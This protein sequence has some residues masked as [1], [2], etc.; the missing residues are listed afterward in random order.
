MNDTMIVGQTATATMR[1]KII[2]GYVQ[3]FEVYPSFVLSLQCEEQIDV[4]K[5]IPD[6][7]RFLQVEASGGLVKI[8]KFMNR[9]Y[10]RVSYLFDELRFHI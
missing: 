4:I 6:Q 10:S 1:G 3:K 2:P 9:H 7:Q 8:T 5:R